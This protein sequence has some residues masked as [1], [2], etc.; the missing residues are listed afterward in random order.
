[1]I[2]GIDFGTTNTRIGTWEPDVGGLPALKMPGL[3][4][5]PI[6][7][8]VISFQRKLGGGAEIEAIG[9]DA[10]GLD[11]R[12]S[13]RVVIRNIKR[14]ALASDSFV[15]RAMEN[16]PS[17][18]WPAYCNPE[19]QSVELWGQS[20]AINKIIM[21]IISEALKRVGLENISA[22][23]RAG[24]PVHSDYI[25]RQNMVN[26]FLQQGGASKL[27]WVTEEP[28]VFLALAYSQGRL[29]EGSYLVYDFGGGSFDCAVAAVERAQDTLYLT[30]YAADGNPLLGG[31]DIDDKLTTRLKYDGPKNLLRIAKE[32]V[33]SNPSGPSQDLPDGIKL[34]WSDVEAVLRDER[35][36]EQTLDV[37]M[38]VYR[39][40]KTIWKRPPDGPPLGEIL[41]IDSNGV[42]KRTISQLREHDLAGDIDKVLLFGGTTRI[43][44]VVQRLEDIFGSEKVVMASK[45]LTAFGE[46]ELT[47][48]AL[49]AAYPPREQY[50]PVYINR[51]PCRVA[52]HL[53]QAS[54]PQTIE[55]IP[56]SH[57]QTSYGSSMLELSRGE[58][59]EYEA[60][61]KDAD[62]GLLHTTGWQDCRMPKYIVSPKQV[63][64]VIDRFGRIFLEMM[65]GIKDAPFYDPLMLLETPPW[66]TSAQRAALKRKLDMQRKYEES[67]R[68]RTLYHLTRNPFRWGEDVG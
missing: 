26:I 45:L 40:A 21:A 32:K 62:G 47:A 14:W 46:P 15:G 36:F 1:M 16:M 56:F 48:V 19:K 3:G 4:M 42:V 60:I 33:C 9:E 13:T 5:R 35:L 49:G 39:Q 10:D 66:Q 59:A 61:V 25:F 24:C 43:R 6:M 17:T 52:L 22:Q 51:L 64:I 54:K 41:D 23:F 57:F 12:T 53:R 29:D 34:S 58:S 30:V 67:E 55:Y 18:P 37:M 8:S 20:I 2:V 11:E 38:R 68:A 50:L 31:M 65:T 7:P 28:L 27:S 63:G 44:S